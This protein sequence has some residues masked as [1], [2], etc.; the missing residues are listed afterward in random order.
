MGHLDKYNEK[1]EFNRGFLKNKLKKLWLQKRYDRMV[2]LNFIS[3]LTDFSVYF[4]EKL[5]LTILG[6]LLIGNLNCFNPFFS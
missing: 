5:F 2:R 6:M 1:K 3:K 4:R